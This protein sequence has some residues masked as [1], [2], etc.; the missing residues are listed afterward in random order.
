VPAT[1]TIFAFLIFFVLFCL[2]FYFGRQ[3]LQTLRWLRTQPN[4]PAEDQQYARRQVKLRLIVCGLLVVLGSQVA[5]TYLFG[6]EDRIRDLAQQIQ[7]QQE[8]NQPV[9]LD[10]EQKALRTVYGIYW[11]AVLAVL[12]TIVLLAAYDIWAIRRYGRRHLKRIND[13]RRAMLEG[14]VARMRSERNGHTT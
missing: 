11:M 13:E 2:A 14:Q 6:L 9:H 5:A 8:A 1:E 3:Q 7:K 4:L 12:A 10:P